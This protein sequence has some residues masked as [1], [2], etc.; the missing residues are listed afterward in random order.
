MCGLR[1]PVCAVAAVTAA[2]RRIA[3]PRGETIES[4]LITSSLAAFQ[5][6]LTYAAARVGSCC[7]STSIV[8]WAALVYELE[9]L[10]V[11][12]GHGGA[13]VAESN[14]TEAE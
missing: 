7:F 8:P 12:T 6:P 4:C 5:R 3:F 14:E 1:L 11:M 2:F 13:G 10:E 9:L